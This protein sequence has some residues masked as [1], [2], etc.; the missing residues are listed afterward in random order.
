MS[1]SNN[2]LFIP[3]DS[4]GQLFIIIHVNYLV[5][6]GEHLV[7]NDHIKKLLSSRF[8][9]KDIKE[10]HYFVGIKVIKTPIGIVICQWHYILN[11]PY[12][13]SMIECKSVPIP[14]DRNLKLDADFSTI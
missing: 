10:L 12:N 11:L 13:F 5:I 9:M 6:G 8:K 4:K 2:S 7:D 14:L 3:S 1:K